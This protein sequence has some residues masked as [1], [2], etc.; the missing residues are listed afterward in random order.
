[1]R[2]GVADT[3]THLNGE[4]IFFKC[5]KLSDKARVGASHFAT[6]ADEVEGIFEGEGVDAHQVGADSCGGSTDPGGAVPVCAL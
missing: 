1:M 2:E 4:W 5:L 3:G 6:G